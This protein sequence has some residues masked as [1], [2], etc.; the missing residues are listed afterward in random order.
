MRFKK[1]THTI[2]R[3]HRNFHTH[4]K[5]RYDMHARAD[6]SK[7]NIMPENMHSRIRTIATYFGLN[8]TKAKS[9]SKSKEPFSYSRMLVKHLN[10][11]VS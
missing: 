2:S 4:L 11:G 7:L 9:S 10:V 5:T 3:D 8:S 1:P 6:S